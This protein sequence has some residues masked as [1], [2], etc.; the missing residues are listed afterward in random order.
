[1]EIKIN[2]KRKNEPFDNKNETTKLIRDNSN[3]YVNINLNID[4]VEIKSMFR[5]SLSLWKKLFLTLVIE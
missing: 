3:N 1:M 4:S 2:L 5:V